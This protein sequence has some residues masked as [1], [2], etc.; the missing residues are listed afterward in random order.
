MGLM[1]SFWLSLVLSII[2][3]MHGSTEAV[4]IGVCYGMNGNDLPSSP[5]VVQLYKQHGIAKMRL[6]DPNP[7]ALEALRGSQIAVSLGTRNED[8]QSIASSQ[9][10]ADSWFT[11]N[12][13][14]YLSDIKFSYITVGNEAIPSQFAGS[15][16]AAMQNLQNTINARG[17]A[18]IKV[19]TVLSSG[20]LGS[21]Y[22]P[23]AGAFSA[24]A[25]EA[26][27]SVL[28]FLSA[29][30][31]PLMINVYPYFAYASDPA[32]IRLDYAQFTA[33]GTVVQDGAL[34]YSNMFDA[35][36]DAF[37]WAMEKEGVSNVGVVV[38]ESGWPSAGNG[39]LTTPELAA[40]YNKNFIQHIMTNGTPKRPQD[41]IE[42]YI[43]AMFNENLKPEG[44]EQHFGLFSPNMQPSYPVFT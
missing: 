5:D 41:H 8:I 7:Q 19:S 26:L 39:E 40:T 4:D 37:Y 28:Q 21:S 13:A 17:V 29:Q 44:T 22:P 14:P 16:G 2:I 18:G 1:T 25:R 38:S 20:T 33:T 23:S 11:N 12:V 36:V 35:I 15:I 32:N 10:A 27:I 34:S 6:F 43:F 42:G 3:S 30:G 24:E 31:S 9:E